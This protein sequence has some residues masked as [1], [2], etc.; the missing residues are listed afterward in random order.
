[1]VEVTVDRDR[2]VAH[3]REIQRAV[4]EALAAGRAAGE[5]AG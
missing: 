5:I 3:H 1:V 4:G 2:S